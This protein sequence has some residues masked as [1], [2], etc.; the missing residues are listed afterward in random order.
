LAEV[1]IDAG[2]PAGVFNVV[3]GA[4]RGWSVADNKSR[5][6]KKCRSPAK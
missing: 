2:V 1:F 5:H 3:Q 4:A 6:C